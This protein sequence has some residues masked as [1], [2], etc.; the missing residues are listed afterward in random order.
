MRNFDGGAHYDPTTPD[1][2][3]TELAREGDPRIGFDSGGLI[4]AT[5]AV[6]AEGQPIKNL[7][8]ASMRQIAWEL[9]QSLRTIGL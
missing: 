2:T 1:D 7:N 9:D 8:R 6:K 5:S 3:Y 4:F